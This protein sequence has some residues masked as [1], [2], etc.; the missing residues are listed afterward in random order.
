MLKQ[1]EDADKHLHPAERGLLLPHRA[2]R[3]SD[4]FIS[5][6]NKICIGWYEIIFL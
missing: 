3:S 2:R 1:I 5:L 4:F 6:T